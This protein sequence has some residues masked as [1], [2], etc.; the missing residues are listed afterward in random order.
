MG[1]SQ[2]KRTQAI[3]NTVAAG[4]QLDVIL[5]TTEEPCNI[6]GL[7]IDLWVGQ[8][9]ATF[10]DFGYWAVS[11]LPRTTTTVPVLNTTNVN[12]E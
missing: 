12:Q 3:D 9:V 1:L 11:I 5:N 2:T 4:A 6:H 8:Q 7:I 10:H